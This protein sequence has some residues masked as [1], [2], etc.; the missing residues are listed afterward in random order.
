[1]IVRVFSSRFDSAKLTL[2]DWK[3]NKMLT[4]QIMLALISIA[5]ARKFDGKV[6]LFYILF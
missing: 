6:D 1:M 5:H 4:F 3:Y 2:P